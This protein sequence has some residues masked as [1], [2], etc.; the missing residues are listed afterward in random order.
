MIQIKVYTQEDREQ[1]TT[2]TTLRNLRPRRYMCGYTF[3]QLLKY[4]KE[5]LYW[6]DI[7]EEDVVSFEIFD[8]ENHWLQPIEKN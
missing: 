6:E 2:G 1:L 3:E 5:E 7:K 4:T 8:K